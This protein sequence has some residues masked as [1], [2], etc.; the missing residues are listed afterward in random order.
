MRWTERV[1]GVGKKWIYDFLN[2]KFLLLLKTTHIS[3]KSA[4]HH[5]SFFKIYSGPVVSVLIASNH[6]AFCKR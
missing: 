3:I 1:A 4:A 5:I 6:Q 2:K